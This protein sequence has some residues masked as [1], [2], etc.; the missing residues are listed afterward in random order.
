M[1]AHILK[2]ARTSDM[3]TNT[4]HN[5]KQNERSKYHEPEAKIIPV[6]LWLFPDFSIHP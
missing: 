5:T 6:N 1:L 2:I 4:I 3:L